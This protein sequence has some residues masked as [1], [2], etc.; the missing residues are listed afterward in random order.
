MPARAP[1]ADGFER[2]ALREIVALTIPDNVPSIRVMES[3]G[4]TPD[5][6]ADF[7]HPLVPVGHR[8]RHHVLYRIKAT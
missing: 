7:E 2:V 5:P 8:M 3:L 1:I 4:M 6:A